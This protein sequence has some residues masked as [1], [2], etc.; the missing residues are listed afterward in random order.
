MKKFVSIFICIIYVLSCETCFAANNLYF[1]KN[2]NKNI[3]SAIVESAFANNKKYNLTKKDPYLA[4]SNKNSSEYELV[5]LQ[6][7][8]NN[9]FYY[10]QSSSGEKTDKAIKKLL[11]NHNIIFEQSENT[12]YLATFENQA[13]KVLTNTKNTYT[14]DEVSN[15]SLSNNSQPSTKKSDNT[16]LKGYV[17]QVAKGATFNTYLDSPIN[18]ATANVGDNVNAILTENWIY[19][20][21]LIAPQGSIVYGVLKKARHA[22]YGSRNGRVVIDFNRIQTPEGKTYDISVEE[23]DFTVSNEG[24]IQSTVSNVAKG[25]VIGALGGLLIGLLSNNGHVGSSTAITAGIGAGTALATST[26]EKGIDAEIPS[27]TELEL[28]LKKPLNVVLSY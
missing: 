19:N 23:I 5:I 24:K 2:T 12:M 6:T 1:L 10:Y 22:T 13:Q 11:K 28:I 18:T 15:N 26:L 27:Y 25:A 20:G 16:V 4:I 7:S 17:G 3:V 14:F 21:N 9:M 8:S